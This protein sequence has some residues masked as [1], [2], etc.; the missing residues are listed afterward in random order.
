MKRRAAASE[1]DVQRAILDYLVLRGIFAW[2]TNSSTTI[3][4]AEGGSK[5]R[6][7]RAH[8]INGVAD[9]L[10][11]LPDGRFMAIEVKS[12]KGRLNLAQQAF[13]EAV[14]ANRAVHCV[15]RNLDDVIKML[16]GIR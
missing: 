5:R 2:R 16:E 10:G 4:A 14:L 9:I 6:F 3:H 11:V 1:H 13:M 15:A 8:S 7:F 12:E